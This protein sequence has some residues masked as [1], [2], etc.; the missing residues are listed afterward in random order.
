VTDLTVAKTILAQ[1]GGER[2]VMMTG[3]T[4]FIGSADSLT[5]KVGSNPK[6]VTHVRV[7]LTPDDLYDMTFFRA[8]KGPQSH[9][10][11]HREMLQ[12]V[13]GAHT[14]LDASLRASA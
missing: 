12:E 5:F 3:A 9:D 1:L 6:R 2:F 8:G 7:T 13:F 14:G 10:G 4:S 11:V